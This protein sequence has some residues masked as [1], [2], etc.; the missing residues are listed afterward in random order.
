MS[1][2]SKSILILGMTVVII[3]L[4]YARHCIASVKPRNSHVRKAVV[5]VS[6]AEVIT[7]IGVILMT[8]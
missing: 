5:A 8:D 2:P 7:S 6:I 1:E 4:T 3:V